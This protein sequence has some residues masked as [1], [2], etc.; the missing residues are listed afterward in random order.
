MSKFLET[1]IRTIQ[2]VCQGPLLSVERGIRKLIKPLDF[3]KA[4]W[5]IESVHEAI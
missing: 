3:N 5:L 1:S 4:G 2:I